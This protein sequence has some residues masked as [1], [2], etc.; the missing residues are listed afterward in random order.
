MKKNRKYPI[1]ILLGISFTVFQILSCKKE[2]KIKIDPIITWSNPTDIT[3][4][5]PLS[6]KQLNATSNTKGSFNYNPGL[7]SVLEVGE[8]QIL[9]C[10]FIPEDKEAFNTLQKTVSINVLAETTVFD[11]DGNEYF[12][13]EIGDQKWLSEN[14]KTTR[15][16]DGTSIPLVTERTKW[17]QLST[18]GYCWYNNEINHKETYG[19]LYNY[20]AVASGN[21]API[22]WRVAT[23]DDWNELISFCGGSLIAGGCLKEYGTSLWIN[24]NLGATDQFG[25]SSRPGGWR[26]SYPAGFNLL[27]S[28]GF[29]WS[30]TA[31]KDGA[32]CIHMEYDSPVINL[33]ISAER[34]GLSVRCIKE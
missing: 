34:Y 1:V 8:N 3:F 7:G 15:F 19:A 17:E 30:S 5:T 32:F 21:L 14:L 31:T 26:W 28:D 2:N 9:N 22:G 27:G 25:F 23:A 13:I 6:D 16:N 18:P 24:P 4:G 29:W 33:S 20:Y 11:A 12:I 10:V